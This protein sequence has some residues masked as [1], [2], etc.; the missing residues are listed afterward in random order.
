[1]LFIDLKVL[2][3]VIDYNFAVA[4]FGCWHCSTPSVKT[5]KLRS[6]CSFN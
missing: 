2:L 4:A 5:T 6:V 1:M 3:Q